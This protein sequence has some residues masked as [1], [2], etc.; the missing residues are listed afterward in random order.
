MP[1][2]V[3]YFKIRW[4]AWRCVWAC[5]EILL[6]RDFSQF[7]FDSRNRF[8]HARQVWDSGILF[9]TRNEIAIMAEVKQR[10]VRQDKKNV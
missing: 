8:D 2:I 1:Y 7:G 5:R 6:A 3:M 9:H 4:Y 10:Y